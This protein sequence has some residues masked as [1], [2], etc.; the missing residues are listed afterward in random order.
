MRVPFNF[1]A[2]QGQRVFTASYV[3]L[4]MQWL[5]INGVNQ[6]ILNGDFTFSGST[7]TLASG[8]NAGDLLF[9][10]AVS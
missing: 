9:G 4:Q 1:V 5:A 10:V 8:L 7:I 6:S 2:T 3:I